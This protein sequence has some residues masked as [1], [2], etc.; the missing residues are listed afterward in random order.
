MKNKKL[1]KLKALTRD[2]LKKVS[3][4]QGGC[5]GGYYTMEY[6]TYGDDTTPGNSLDT[7]GE[8][9]GKWVLTY[10]PRVC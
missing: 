2:D 5:T 1:A 6:V 9:D 3:G 10:H 8:D 4:G 7:G